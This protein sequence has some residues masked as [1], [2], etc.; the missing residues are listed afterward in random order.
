M[1]IAGFVVACLPGMLA[2]HSEPSPPVPRAQTGTG[3]VVHWDE[4][5]LNLEPVVPAAASGVTAEELVLAL[6]SAA[7]AW[8][9]PLETCAVP[10]V[11]IR[12]PTPGGAARVDGRSV[13]VLRSDAWCPADRRDPSDCYDPKLQALT[14]LRQRLDGKESDDGVLSEADIEVNAVDF[15]WSLDGQRPG[16]RSLRAILAHEL[17]HVLGL[18]H[19]CAE[20]PT[21]AE[22]LPLCAAEASR[23]MKI[24]IMYPDPTEPGRVPVLAPGPD[25]TGP[26]CH[27]RRLRRAPNDDAAETEPSAAD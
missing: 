3:A 8:N 4:D 11:R 5:E 12:T 18:R 25:A 1:N 10:R 27:E 26:L 24:S 21:A 19:P 17:G 9:E 23:A 20:R 6:Q 15:R 14:Q 16:T 22:A 2:C 7:R 13:V